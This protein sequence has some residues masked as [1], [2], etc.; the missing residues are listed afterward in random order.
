MK[1]YHEIL[2]T[3]KSESNYYI[4]SKKKFQ[5]KKNKV[6]LLIKNLKIIQLNKKLD[7]KKV[8]FFFIKK[9]K[10]KFNYKLNF[11]KEIKIYPIFH[12]FLLEPANLEIP[13]STKFSKLLPENEYKVEKIIDYDHKNQ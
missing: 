13:V 6:Y 10:D 8:G 11:P 5:L 9:Q 12:I 3:N 7:H 2:N 1:K 4:I